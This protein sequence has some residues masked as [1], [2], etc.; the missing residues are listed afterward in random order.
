MNFFCTNILIFPYILR[1]TSLTRDNRC[2]A[3]VSLTESV[4]QTVRTYRNTL[5][6]TRDRRKR[7]RCNN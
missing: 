3:D 1:F 5:Q 7:R 4:N 2:G 6:T